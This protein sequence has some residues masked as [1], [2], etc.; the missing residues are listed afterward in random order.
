[1]H[2]ADY[3]NFNFFNY[4]VIFHLRSNVK[5]SFKKLF[6]SEDRG[7]G[8]GR[9]DEVELG[10]IGEGSKI[11]FTNYISFYFAHQILLCL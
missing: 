10:C 4:E 7:W 2:S 9:A 11:Y 8:K 5:R 6:F 3:E 1:M